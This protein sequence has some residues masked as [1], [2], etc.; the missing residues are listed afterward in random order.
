MQSVLSQKLPAQLAAVPSHSV[1]CR[2]WNLLTL[3][4]FPGQ[5]GPGSRLTGHW[6]ARGGI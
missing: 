5:A 6:Q 1:A 2:D 3:L 4:L